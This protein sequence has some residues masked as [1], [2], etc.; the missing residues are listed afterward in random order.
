[1]FRAIIIGA[2][3][4]KDEDIQRLFYEP[5]EYPELTIF[6]PFMGSGTTIGEAVKLGLRVIGRD[7]NP[8]P[9]TMTSAALQRYD[10]KTVLDTFSALTESVAP[11]IRSY[12][13]TCLPNSEPADVL[14]YFWV[15]TVPCP[16]CQNEVELFKSRIFSRNAMPNK[17]P[18]AKSLCPY[19]RSINDTTFDAEAAT[20]NV[21]SRTYNPQNGTVNNKTVECPSCKHTFAV[22]D[23]VRRLGEPPSHRMYAKL[24]LT[25]EGIKTY[26]PIDDKDNSKYQEIEQSLP[27]LFDEIPQLQILPG[28]NTN[29]ML[30]YNYQFW[31]Q[32]FNARQQASFVLLSRGVKQI[33]SPELRTLFACLLSS[34]LEF[35]NMF[36]SFKGEGTGAVRPI[37]SHHILKPE[38]TPLEANV[39]GTT[40]SSGS[41]STLFETRVLRAIEYKARPFEFQLSKS[42]GQLRNQKVFGLSRSIDKEVV[43]NYQDFAVSDAVY[44]SCGDSAHTDIPGNSVD[45]IITDPPFFDNVHYSELADFF[46]VWLRQILSNSPTQQKTTRSEREVQDTSGSRFG[47]KLTDV[48]NECRRVL[49]PD[50]LLAFTYHHSRIEGWSSLYEALHGSSFTVTQVHP[51]KSEMAVSVPVQQSKSPI[52]FDLIIVCRPVGF[53]P[54]RVSNSDNWADLTYRE[55]KRVVIELLSASITLSSADVKVMLMGNALRSLSSLGPSLAIPLLQRFESEAE[56]IATKLLTENH[57]Q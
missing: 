36:C 28:Y 5:R 52:T 25:S 48:F 27:E 8:I 22:I 21:C 47:E 9:L 53:L 10:K 14:Y 26:L 24:V 16:A 34:T 49:K 6:D 55:T 54:N 42:S 20:C 40:K 1:V 35:N 41:F 32:M 51:V 33:D 12:Y 7:I 29:Q 57:R 44:L 50:G 15:K 30:K 56:S 13:S 11:K 38:L 4:D 3:E 19:C 46:F 43:G 17:R 23:A 45:L 18:E 39:W 2:S 37:F 31:H